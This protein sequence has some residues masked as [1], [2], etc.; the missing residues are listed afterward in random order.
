LGLGNVELTLWTKIREH[1]SSL[2]FHEI[3][4]HRQIKR[5]KLL[6][7]QTCHQLRHSPAYRCALK[8]MIKIEKLLNW[9]KMS[10]FGQKIIGALN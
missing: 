7:F 10:V 9:K 5:S 2:K 8:S 6:K 3:Y 1:H 4:H